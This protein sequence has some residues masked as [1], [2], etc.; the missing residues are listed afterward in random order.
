MS[1]T[2]NDNKVHVEKLRETISDASRKAQVLQTCIK[3]LMYAKKKAER[4]SPKKMRH[5][6]PHIVHPL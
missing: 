1:D 2:K 5:H 4:H 3:A 6:H